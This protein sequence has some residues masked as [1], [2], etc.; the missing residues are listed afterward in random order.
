[1]PV[2]I[3]DNCRV[4]RVFAEELE[5]ECTIFERE[6]AFR[7]VDPTQIRLQTL[8]LLSGIP[9][10]DAV[11]KGPNGSPEVTM[12]SGETAV[13]GLPDPRAERNVLTSDSRRNRAS[14]EAQYY[15]WLTKLHPGL[16]RSL[17][18]HFTGISTGISVANEKAIEIFSF[19]ESNGTSRNN[20]GG[21]EW[22][23]G[24]GQLM[25]SMEAMI[26]KPPW[27]PRL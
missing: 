21:I 18:L 22:P 9:G 6:L 24:L 4:N 8:E 27:A 1:M 23:S 19:L 3:Y 12:R 20:S 25:P 15:G 13:I 17:H 16:G 7:G 10:V 11:T 14:A 5:L 26:R 2:F